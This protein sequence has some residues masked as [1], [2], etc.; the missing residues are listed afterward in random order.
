[1]K[2]SSEFDLSQSHT[3]FKLAWIYIKINE[4]FYIYN[5]FLNN[6]NKLIIHTKCFQ[7]R[8]RTHFIQN[9]QTRQKVLLIS[10]R[11]MIQE[12]TFQKL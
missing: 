7:N 4:W 3:R 6:E 12:Y 11:K 5:K 2:F 8:K 1:M 9:C 10:R